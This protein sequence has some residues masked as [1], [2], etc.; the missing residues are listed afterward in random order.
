MV[1]GDCLFSLM[2][3]DHLQFPW[4]SF[5]VRSSM[6]DLPQHD[7]STK[8]AEIGLLV[9]ETIETMYKSAKAGVVQ[10]IHETAT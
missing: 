5:A 4:A 9:V 10:P 7:L 2:A 3:L 6:F 1:A 8:D